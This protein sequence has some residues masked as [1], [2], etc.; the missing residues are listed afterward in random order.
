[1][2]VLDIAIEVDVAKVFNVVFEVFFDVDVRVVGFSVNENPSV[3]NGQVIKMPLENLG[4][5]IVSIPLPKRMPCRVKC[6]KWYSMRVLASRSIGSP[7]GL[8]FLGNLTI[9]QSPL[10]SAEWP[11]RPALFHHLFHPLHCL[12]HIS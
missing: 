10:Y 11:K 3:P 4:V 9:F 12:L 1:V 8:L 7:D 5:E 6:S 2:V